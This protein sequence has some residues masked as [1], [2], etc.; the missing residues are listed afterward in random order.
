MHITK[1]RNSTSKNTIN[2]QKMRFS[3]GV[4]LENAGILW[5]NLYTQNGH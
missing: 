5:Y 3:F 1:F 2:Y 4:P